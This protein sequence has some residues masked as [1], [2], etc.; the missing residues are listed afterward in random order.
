MAAGLA[1]GCLAFLLALTFE[2]V[3]AWSLRAIVWLWKLQRA[4]SALL[5]E[6]NE[7]SSALQGSC[8]CQHVCMQSAQQQRPAAPNDRDSVCNAAQISLIVAEQLKAA[9]TCN[10][11]PSQAEVTPLS[12]RRAASDL[13]FLPETIYPDP[14]LDPCAPMQALAVARKASSAAK[15][16]QSSVSISHTVHSAPTNTV[17]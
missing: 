4:P 13:L 12:A 9:D 7:G 16:I 1:I 8:I 2:P 5:T 10:G 17:H 15:G 14:Y 11:S 3:R 6:D